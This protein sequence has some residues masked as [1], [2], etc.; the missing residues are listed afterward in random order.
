LSLSTRRMCLT[1]R[2]YS[3][4]TTAKF[5][6]PNNRKPCLLASHDTRATVREATAYPAPL[7]LRV[8]RDDKESVVYLASVGLFVFLIACQQD[9]YQKCIVFYPRFCVVLGS[10]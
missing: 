6:T 8:D 10:S 5:E 1:A 7:P 9:V 4:A 2:V 3:T